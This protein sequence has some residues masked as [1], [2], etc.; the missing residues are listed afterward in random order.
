MILPFLN[1]VFNFKK[2]PITWA[3]F[4]LNLAVYLVTIN[5]ADTSREKI[6]YFLG[7]EAFSETQGLLFAKYIQEH[8]ERYPASLR[9]L[10]ESSIE[11]VNLENR[12]L[13]GNMAL[14]DSSFL[15]SSSDL[16]FEGDEVAF[17]WWQKKYKELEEIKDNNFSYNLGVM[18]NHSSIERLISYQF[19]HSG[20]SH[21]FGNMIFFMIFLIG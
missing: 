12:H 3:L 13:L 15:E 7:D 5:G 21:F 19:S 20:F 10:A 14:R 8:K 18:Q 11:G 9:F 16:K 6:E 17:A 4:F 2:T 1:G